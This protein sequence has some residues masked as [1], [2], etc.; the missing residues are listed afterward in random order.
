MSSA[1]FIVLAK[2][3]VMVYAIE[4]TDPME[5]T[6]FLDDILLVWYCKTLQNHKA[7]LFTPRLDGMYF[8]ATYN[9]DKDEMYLDAYRKQEN[10]KYDG[11]G[12]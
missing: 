5:D 6:I 9:G 11:K 12:R 7:L 2:T 10:I 4:H 1:D 3:R 8:E